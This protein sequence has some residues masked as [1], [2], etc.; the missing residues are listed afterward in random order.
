MNALRTRAQSLREGFVAE[1]ADAALQV[2]SRHKVGGTSVEQELGFWK[3]L[4]PMVSRCL[5]GIQAPTGDRDADDFVA[6][7]AEAAY[8]A[9][10]DY[11]FR[12]SFLDLQ[13]DLWKAFRRVVQESSRA[14]LF[15]RSFCSRANAK[16][17][18]R[19]G[20]GFVLA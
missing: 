8:Q 10:L 13:L 9:S 2:A 6:A 17:G 14:Q 5:E 11:G 15:L 12:D 20:C 19:R 1:L 16:K 18:R 4:V 7:L 3:A